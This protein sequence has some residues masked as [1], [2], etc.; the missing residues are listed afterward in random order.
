MNTVKTQKELLQEYEQL[1]QQLSQVYEQLNNCYQTETE[2]ILNIIPK[3][4]IDVLH[5][6]YK[7]ISSINREIVELTNERDDTIDH[8]TSYQEELSKKYNISVIAIEHY[9]TSYM[10]SLNKENCEQNT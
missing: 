7:D 4:E 1:K 8:A 6:Y 3:L 9:I 10:M 2:N 5:E